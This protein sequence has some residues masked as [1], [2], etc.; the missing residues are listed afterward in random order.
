MAAS[1]LGAPTGVYAQTQLSDWRAAN[2]AVGRFLRGHIDIVRAENKSGAANS[3]VQSDRPANALTLEQ[4][5]KT[6][7]TSTC[8][9]FVSTDRIKR[10]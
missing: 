7:V 5:K 9:G 8:R 2:D 4:A 3:G 6:R 10:Q 1:L